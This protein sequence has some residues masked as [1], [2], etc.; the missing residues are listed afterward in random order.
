MALYFLIAYLLIHSY[1]LNEFDH[2]YIRIHTLYVLFLL[3]KLKL[4]KQ[5]KWYIINS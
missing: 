3:L 2:S 4:Q 1:I 5:N